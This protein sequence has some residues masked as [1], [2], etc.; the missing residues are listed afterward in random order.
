MDGK[1]QVH[2]HGMETSDALEARIRDRYDQLERRCPNLTLCRV[3]VEKESRHH[4]SGN[5]FRVGIVLHRPGQDIVA[6]RTGPREQGHADVY[7][8]LRDSFDAAERQLA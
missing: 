2:F 1:L 3:T 6:G 4:R 8:A 7:T 5:L